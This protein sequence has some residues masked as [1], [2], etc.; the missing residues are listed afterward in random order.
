MQQM[1]LTLRSYELVHTNR[2]VRYPPY[3]CF[4]FKCSAL[5]TL[6][7]MVVSVFSDLNCF[8][9]VNSAQSYERTGSK[10]Q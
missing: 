6:K 9:L 8:G 1:S 4:L 5:G 10:K 7:E 3:K 2:S